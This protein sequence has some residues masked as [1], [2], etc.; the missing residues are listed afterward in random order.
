MLATVCAKEKIRLDQA[1]KT[2]KSIYSQ[3]SQHFHGNDKR[4]TIDKEV[5][6]PLEIGATLRFFE[7]Q[8]NWPDPMSFGVPPK[9]SGKLGERITGRDEDE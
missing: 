4:M 1:E 3:L 6:C 2:C 8:K 7:V 9:K 5:F